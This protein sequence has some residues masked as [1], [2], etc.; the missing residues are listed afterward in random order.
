MHE[1]ISDNDNVDQYFCPDSKCEYNVKEVL[2][3]FT[4]RNVGANCPNCDK[5]LEL[6]AKRHIHIKLPTSNDKTL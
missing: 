1:N 3:V 5:P 6:R 4:D 2:D